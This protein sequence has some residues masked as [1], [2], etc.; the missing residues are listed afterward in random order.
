VSDAKYDGG[1][2]RKHRRRTEMIQS[3]RHRA[4]LRKLVLTGN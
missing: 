3:N 1:E 4:D 2:Q